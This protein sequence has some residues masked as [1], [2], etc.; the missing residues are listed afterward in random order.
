MNHPP[1]PKIRQC[2]GFLDASER[3]HAED[4]EDRD[5]DS[6]SPDQV[7]QANAA[8]PEL[9]DRSSPQRRGRPQCPHHQKTPQRQANEEADLPETAELNIRQALIAEPEPVLVDYPHDAE[10]IADQRT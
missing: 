2:E 5:V 4:I 10:I 3:D 6:G 9:S 1:A 7:F 8:S